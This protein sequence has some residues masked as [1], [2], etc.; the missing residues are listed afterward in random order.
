MK[1]KNILTTVAALVISTSVY[2]TPQYSGSTI[3]INGTFNTERNHATDNTSGYYIWNYVNN[4]SKWALRWTGNNADT[5]NSSTIGGSNID[6]FGSITFGSN[7]LG[8]VTEKSFD[9]GD[10]SNVYPASTP[11]PINDTFTWSAV[12]NDTGGWDGINFELASYETL[13]SFSLGSDLY[14]DVDLAL[15]SGS[16]VAS[17]GIYIGGGTTSGSPAFNTTNV[18]VKDYTTGRRVQSFEISVVPEPSIIALFGLGLV[19]LG[20]AGRRRQQS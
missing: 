11:F 17:K 2:A 12:T 15:H 10:I 1:I 8:T 7:G 9:S 14:A 18:L 3:G 13:L 16:G 19:G 20:F 6:W 5:S 4:P